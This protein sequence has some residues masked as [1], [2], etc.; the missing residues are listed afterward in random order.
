[1]D[2]AGRTVLVA[3]YGGGGVE[4]RLDPKTS[5]LTPATPPSAPLAPGSGPRRLGVL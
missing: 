3:N 1:V 2:R 4:Y 5:A